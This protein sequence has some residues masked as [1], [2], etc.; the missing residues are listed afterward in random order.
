MAHQRRDRVGLVIAHQDAQVTLPI[1]DAMLSC[2]ASAVDTSYTQHNRTNGST[3]SLVHGNMADRKLFSVSIYPT[4]TIVLWERPTRQ[5][6]FDFALANLE[7][8]LKPAHA[9]GTWFDDWNQVHVLDVV[10]L[11]P[12]RDAALALALCH[13]QI[14]IFDLESRC[15]IPVPH[16]SE[17]LLAS[18]AGGA[19]V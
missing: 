2:I 4:R 6:L 17:I 12:D 11:V 8:L 15:E 3:V 19:N 1:C 9:L 14:A 16:Q 13:G 10:L 18:H 7:L 5:E